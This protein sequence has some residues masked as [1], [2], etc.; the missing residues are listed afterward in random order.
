MLTQVKNI[1]CNAVDKN[2][3][4]KKPADCTNPK[5]CM[6]SKITSTKLNSHKNK[7]SSGNCV[8]DNI[9]PLFTCTNF[10]CSYCSVHV[11]VKGFLGFL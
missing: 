1:F 6:V 4:E 10:F 5:N 8:L 11:R 3:K 7:V 9:A 2:K